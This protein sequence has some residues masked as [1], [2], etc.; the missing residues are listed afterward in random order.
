M[1]YRTHKLAPEEDVPR[2][3]TN[4]QILQVILDYVDQCRKEEPRR[5]FDDTWLRTIGPMVD[6]NT[7]MKSGWDPRKHDDRADTVPSSSCRLG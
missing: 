6:W 5:Y 7:V 1:V 2:D 4:E 3:A